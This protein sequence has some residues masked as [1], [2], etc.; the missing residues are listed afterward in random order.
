MG[1][2]FYFPHKT[3]TYSQNFFPS[4]LNLYL[5]AKPFYFPHKTSTYSQNLFPS[6]LNLY[7]SWLKPLSLGKT[8]L[9]L[10]KTFTS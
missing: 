9:F 6:W 3:S 10:G 2:P 8:F 4:W 5:L 7:I 1:K